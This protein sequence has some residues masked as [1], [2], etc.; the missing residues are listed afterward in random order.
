MRL[1]KTVWFK[2]CIC[3][4]LSRA[5]DTCLVPRFGTVT[6]PHHPFMSLFLSSAPNFPSPISPTSTPLLSPHQP[7]F[8]SISSCSLRS[9]YS[10]PSAVHIW[11]IASSRTPG[12]HAYII[13]SALATRAAL[14]TE[15]EIWLLVFDIIRCGGLLVCDCHCIGWLADFVRC[16]VSLWVM[17][18]LNVS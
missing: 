2:P 18:F 10:T 14:M 6:P 7:L 5:H 4:Y 12:P 11:M 8:R 17:V 1:F 13:Q 15:P 9:V 3:T 16:L